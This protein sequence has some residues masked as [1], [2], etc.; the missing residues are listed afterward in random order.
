[1]TLAVYHSHHKKGIG[2]YLLGLGIKTLIEKGCRIIELGV[3]G[4]NAHALAL[5][6]RFGF[7]EVESQTEIDFVYSP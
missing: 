5:Y 3:E 4:E 7:K 2:S 1:M 6:K